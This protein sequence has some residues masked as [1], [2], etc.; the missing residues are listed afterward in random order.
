MRSKLVYLRR[1]FFSQ[2]IILLLFLLVNLSSNNFAA[3]N[4]YIHNF[5]WIGLDSWIFQH[6]LTNKQIED[7]CV[8]KQI[9]QFQCSF[10]IRR[11]FYINKII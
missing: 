11:F 7:Y 10:F 5:N 4:W 3:D 9:C 8:T 6:A 2:D 1:G